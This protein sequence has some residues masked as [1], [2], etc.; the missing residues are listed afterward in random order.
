MTTYMTDFFTTCLTEEYDMHDSDGDLDAYFGQFCE[1]GTVDDEHPNWKHECV[2]DW[3]KEILSM[4][5]GYDDMSPMLKRAIY[6][7]VDE[8]VI[9]ELIREKHKE[10]YESEHDEDAD[11]DSEES[12]DDEEQTD[13]LPPSEKNASAAD[14]ANPSD[15]S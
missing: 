13:P 12:A 14:G 3:V 4:Q 2:S 7:D 15:V 6:M 11:S 9:L 10:W 5:P 8:D 1:A